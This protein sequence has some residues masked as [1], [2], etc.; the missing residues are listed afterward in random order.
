MTSVVVNGVVYELTNEPIHGIVRAMKERQK[1]ITIKFLSQNKE[2]LPTD[3]MKIDDAMMLLVKE[4][5]M[6]MADYSSEIEELDRI[7]TISLATGHLFTEEDF[8]NVKES[9]LESVYDECSK[10]LGGGMISFFER[11]RQNTSLRMKD[12][13]LTKKQASP[14]HKASNDS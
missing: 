12:A 9:D 4:R 10:A 14:K 11:S 7:G 8:F 13:G 2:I 6:E 3:K 5:P 1:Q